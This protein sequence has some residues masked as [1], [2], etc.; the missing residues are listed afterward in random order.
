MAAA[1]VTLVDDTRAE[2]EGLRYV[3]ALLLLRKKRLKVVR[4]AGLA[5]GDLL[6]RDPRDEAGEKTLY[7]ETPDFSPEALDRLKDQLGEILD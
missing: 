5:R 3:V 4:R 1:V 6:F 2:V 7:L